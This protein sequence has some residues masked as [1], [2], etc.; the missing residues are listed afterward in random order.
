MP[1]NEKIGGMG[2]AEVRDMLL[3]RG[4]KAFRDMAG[5]LPR[6]TDKVGNL[7]T[8]TIDTVHVHNVRWVSRGMEWW[9][10]ETNVFHQLHMSCEEPMCIY[11]AESLSHFFK[12]M[13]NFNASLVDGD[14]CCFCGKNCGDFDDIPF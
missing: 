2:E 13:I 9:I 14:L 1:K 5:Y 10:E 7:P 11:C 8:F 4:F 12:D 6:K 3:K